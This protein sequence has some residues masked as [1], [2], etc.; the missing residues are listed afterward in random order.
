MK[1]WQEW[2]AT[3]SVRGHLCEGLRRGQEAGG[4]CKP[5]Y[6]EKGS[7]SGCDDTNYVPI[8]FC[9]YCGE[10]I[11]IE[12]DEYESEWSTSEYIDAATGESHH[13]VAGGYD[14]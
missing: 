6:N 2:E 1:S 13:G 8:L 14:D 10:R 7:L 12:W 5:R 11:P 9:P 3:P 4:G